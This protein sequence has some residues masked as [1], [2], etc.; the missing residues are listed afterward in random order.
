MMKQEPVLRDERYYAVE[1]ASYKIGYIL[2]AGSMMLW[3][4]FRSIVYQESNW[5]VFGLV[6]VSSLAVTAYQVKQKILQFDKRVV[7]YVLIV[8]VIAAAV[9]FIL[10]ALR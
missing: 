1:N 6:W 3:V 10:K 7:V 5:I 4:I 9:P 8:T 2:L